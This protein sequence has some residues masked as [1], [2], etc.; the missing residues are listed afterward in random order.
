MFS[1]S[2]I[3]FSRCPSDFFLCNWP[4]KSSNRITQNQNIAWCRND[5][6]KKFV[7]KIKSKLC[8]I[9]PYFILKNSMCQICVES[10]PYLWRHWVVENNPMNDKLSRCWWHLHKNLPLQTFECII[11]LY[12]VINLYHLSF[13]QWHTQ[14]TFHT[15]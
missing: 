13:R 4:L 2:G 14:Y 8:G 12:K 15:N 1:V 9:C 6:G 5:E 7:P 3:K 11:C 10:Y